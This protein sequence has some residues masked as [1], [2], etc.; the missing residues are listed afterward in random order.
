MADNEN[1]RYQYKIYKLCSDDCDEF[2]IGSTRDF[3]TRKSNHKSGCNNPNNPQYN[4]KKSKTIREFGGWE[5]W[6]MVVIKLMENATK[7]EAEMQEDAYRVEMNAQ[8]NSMKATR[9][10]MTIE[11][12]RK[13]H[14]IDNKEYY[15]QHNNQY[16]KNNKQQLSEIRNKKHNCECG[17]RY[18]QGS[19]AR[20]MKTQKHQNYISNNNL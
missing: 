13:Q 9:G 4:C 20:H 2:Y 18:V 1:K 5:N 14:Y 7:L 8:L 6:R 15:I 11:E 16:Y 19:I 3:T 12:Y 17:G 10:L